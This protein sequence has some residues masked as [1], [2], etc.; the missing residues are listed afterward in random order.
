MRYL[1]L[2]AVVIVIGGITQTQLRKNVGE[3]D[4]SDWFGIV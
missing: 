2:V 1:L 4:F 3:S